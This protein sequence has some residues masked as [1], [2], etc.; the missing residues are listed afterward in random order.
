MSAL[1]PAFAPERCYGHLSHQRACARTGEEGHDQASISID[2]S[3]S[4]PGSL[5]HTKH[6]GGGATPASAR[7]RFVANRSA[8]RKAAKDGGSIHMGGER[9]E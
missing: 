7:R 2:A 3:L 4:G 8:K 9:D 6:A 1:H 5:A